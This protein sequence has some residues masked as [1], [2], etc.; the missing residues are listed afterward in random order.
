ML[1]RSLIQLE[2]S[3]K[4]LAAQNTLL[5][6]HLETVSNQAN[7]IRQAADSIAT[8]ATAGDT[9]DGDADTKASESLDL[10][11]LTSARRRRLLISS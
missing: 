1:I 8:E 10:L 9:E 7:R 3:C 4:D 2:R 5:H 6:Q 11:F